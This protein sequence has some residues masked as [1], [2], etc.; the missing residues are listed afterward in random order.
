VETSPKDDNALEIIDLEQEPILH[1]EDV[2]NT[3]E[4]V[5][6]KEPGELDDQ[7]YTE[8]SYMHKEYERNDVDM[9][10]Q[11]DIVEELES[12]SPPPKTE[13]EQQDTSNINI[14]KS[15]EKFVVG[16]KDADLER[17]LHYFDR[18]KVSYLK[19]EDM[20]NLFHSLGQSFSKRYVRDLVARVCEPSKSHS[21]R[22][23]YRVLFEQ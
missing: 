21:R 7:E 5:E 9:D 11:E 23:Y 22:F 17:A 8:P 3:D 10:I 1:E 15:A 12:S 2:E 19:S 20:E 18:E 13:E 14:N 16:K 4:P 6:M